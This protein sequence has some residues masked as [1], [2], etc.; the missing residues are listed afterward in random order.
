MIQYDFKIAN[1]FI[2]TGSQRASKVT[3]IVLVVVIVTSSGTT[4]IYSPYSI[5]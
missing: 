1:G 3:L 4:T 2:R 5:N